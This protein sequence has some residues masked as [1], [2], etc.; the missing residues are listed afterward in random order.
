MK[1]LLSDEET[2]IHTMQNTEFLGMLSI[3]DAI[4]KLFREHQSFFTIVFRLRKILKA[5]INMNSSMSLTE[6]L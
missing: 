6:V 5:S 4:N 2:F 3:F 1:S